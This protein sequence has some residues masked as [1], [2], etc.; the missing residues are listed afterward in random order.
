MLKNKAARRMRAVTRGMGG[1]TP[2]GMG[3]KTPRGMGGKSP[4]RAMC[5]LPHT[6]RDYRQ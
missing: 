2:R 3:G 5:P 1:K 6:P 4:G